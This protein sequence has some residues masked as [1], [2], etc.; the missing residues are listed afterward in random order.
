MILLI[1]VFPLVNTFLMAMAEGETMIFCGVCAMHISKHNN[2]IDGDCG[3]MF[4]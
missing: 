4:A 1:L 2:D 3:R